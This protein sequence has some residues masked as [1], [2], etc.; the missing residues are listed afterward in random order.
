[1]STAQLAN[2]EFRC[3]ASDTNV[4]DLKRSCRALGKKWVFQLEKSDSGYEHF[5]GSISLMKRR[6][7][8]EAKALWTSLHETGEVPS[9][10]PNYFAPKCTQNQGDLF[11]VTKLD[12][13][14]D[15]PWK[16][17]DEEVYIPLDIRELIKKESFPSPWQKDVIDMVDKFEVRKVDVI[18]DTKGGKGK[19]SL[20]RYLGCHGKAKKIPFAN[21]YKDI[22]RMVMDMPTQKMYFIDMPRAIGKERLFQLYGAIEEIK[23]GYAFDDRY[24]FKD[25]Y[26][27][28]PRVV[29][30]TN[31]PPDLNLLSR[32]R[33]NLWSI[34]ETYGLVPYSEDAVGEERAD[35]HDVGQPKAGGPTSRA[36]RPIQG[37][38][39]SVGRSHAHPPPT[40]AEGGAG[41]SGRC[42]IF[43]PHRKNHPIS[44][45][46][47]ADAEEQFS[48][49]QAGHKRCDSS[50]CDR[51][52][53]ANVVSRLQEP[54]CR[55]KIFQAQASFEATQGQCN[56]AIQSYGKDSG[57]ATTGKSGLSP[58][59]S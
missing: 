49:H 55:V 33:W 5:Q 18:I 15:G 42:K 8:G 22:M 4:E 30:I 16:D 50:A 40:L 19:S 56:S 34:S 2:F 23:S 39:E 58:D 24:S 21:D 26:F 38:C 13:R 7:V 43:S 6:R 51:G 25:K 17:T 52:H 31:T 3:N 54:L 44:D 1:M 47:H 11:Y 53:E 32:D 14:L 35:E 12:T 10:L 36:E 41:G 20:V 28:P 45:P 46:R 37:A 59:G 9:P 27:D 48:A 29:V 57:V